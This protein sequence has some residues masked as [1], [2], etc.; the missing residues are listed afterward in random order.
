MD[1][2]KATKGFIALTSEIDC[3]QTA[4]GLPPVTFAVFLI[5]K[6]LV[7]FG[8]SESILRCLCYP[9]GDKA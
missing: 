9:F 7:K 2:E 6:F 1:A 3:D 8:A 5:V 4:K